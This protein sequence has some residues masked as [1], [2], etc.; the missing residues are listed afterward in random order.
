[1]H[2]NWLK[3]AR[4]LAKLAAHPLTV[5]FLLAAGLQSLP[6]TSKMK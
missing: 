3:M 1:M 5:L 2:Y 4:D 6:P